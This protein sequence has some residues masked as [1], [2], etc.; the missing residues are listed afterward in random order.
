VIVDT[1]AIV[2]TYCNCHDLK[3]DRICAIRTQ[4]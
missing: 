4:P 1:P 2:F 3:G